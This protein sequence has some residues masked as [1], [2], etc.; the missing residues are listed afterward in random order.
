[1]SKAQENNK[2]TKTPTLYTYYGKQYDFNDL[3]KDSDLGFK[4]YLQTLRRGDKDAEEL[5]NAY[6]NIMSGIGDGSI[7]FEDGRFNDSLGR[8]SNG[9]YYDSEGKKQTSKK[10]SKDYYGLVANYI[11]GKLGKSKEYQAPEDDTK[12]KWNGN[13]SLGLAFNRR[14]FNSDNGNIADFIDLDPYNEETKT[15]ST[16]NRVKQAKE[17]TKYLYDNFDSLFTNYSDV[18]SQQARQYLKDAMT[19][20]DD[21][22]IDSGDYLALSRAF[23]GINWRNMF[24]TQKP[25]E[26]QQEQQEQSQA[27]VPLTP[28]QKFAQWVEERY[29]KYTGT[30]KGAVSLNSG[31][32]YG[33]YTTKTLMNAM[34]NL[35]DTDL[36]RIVRSSVGDRNYV[37]NNEQFVQNTFPGQDFGFLNPFGLQQT[38]QVMM[39]RGLL[40]PFDPNKSTLYYIPYTATKNNT[41]WVW[42]SANNTIQEMSIRD[43]PFWRQR[44]LTE[45][46]K[47]YPAERN[48]DLDWAT[49][50]LQ[51]GG[52]I[53]AQGGTQLWYSALRDY[54]PSKYKSSYDTSRLVNGDMSDDNFDAWVSNINGTGIGRYKPSQGN[55]REYTQGIENQEYYKAFG[56]SL[57]N[58]DGSFTDIGV[59]WAKAVDA[60][61]PKGSMASFYDDNGNLRTSW[62]VKNQDVYGRS[63]RTFNN[64]QDYV[65]YVRNDQ[66]LGARHNVFLNQGNRY[67]YIDENQQKHWVD[68]EQISNYTVSETP[69]QSGWNEDKTVYWNDYQLTGLKN[70]TQPA[71]QQTTV[72]TPAQN[73]TEPGNIQDGT[74]VLPRQDVQPNKVLGKFG[75]SMSRIAPDLISAGRLFASLRTNNRVTNTIMKSL[76]PVLKDTYERYSPITGAFGEMQFR[77]NQASDLRSQASKPFTSDASLQLA[78][79]LEAD[80]QSRDLEYQGFLADNR[81]IQRT[82]EAAL[83]RQEDNMARRSEVSNFNRASINQTNREKAELAATGL[84]RN[85]QSVD[86]FAQGIEGRLRN[87]IDQGI[88]RRNNFRLQNAMFDA[89]NK[90]QNAIQSAQDD[91]ETWRANNPGVPISRM[92]KYSNYVKYIRDMQR[93][94]QA[95]QYQAHA[96]IYGYNYD[97]EW[98]N[99]TP[100]SIGQLYGYRK[101]GSLRPSTMYLINKVIKNESNT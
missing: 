81:E 85:W 2:E 45:Y 22:S 62:T 87:R 84:R 63:P 27:D 40:N 59:A 99:K 8:Y 91:V 75:E 67:F 20:L 74:H 35:R 69:V 5:W 68:P 52:I 1:M 60:N 21:G 101:G 73:E 82:R 93:W 12:I 9:V 83:A 4:D 47:G 43:I 80:R 96:D 53:K 72:Q 36:Y 23:G 90:Y 38:L 64:L 33:D 88:E 98:V 51:K 6:S 78:G 28:A 15:R 46:K 94:R 56:N 18:E 71:S 10:R 17:V 16:G 76:N 42:D 50:Y 92:P 39:K 86:N 61:L 41:G 97:N 49:P 13:N 44:I 30:L 32:T 11:A 95:Q 14:M 66:I 24:T 25:S 79:Q 29:P 34:S 31:R 65:N 58:P 7:T 89:D 100:E 70:S 26:Q 3:R 57:F 77:N 37:F 55:T 48:D 54:D 19:S